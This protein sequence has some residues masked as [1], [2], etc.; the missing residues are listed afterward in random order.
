MQ[1]DL[2]NQVF[3]GSTRLFH[4]NTAAAV[5]RLKI[6]SPLISRLLFDYVKKTCYEYLLLDVSN[7][8]PAYHVI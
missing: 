5:G 6:A 2:S 3:S 1:G 4:P 8:N 7:L